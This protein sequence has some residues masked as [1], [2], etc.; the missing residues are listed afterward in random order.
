M[1][2]DFPRRVLRRSNPSHNGTSGDYRAARN[3]GA[4]G[5]LHRVTRDNLRLEKTHLADEPGNMAGFRKVLDGS[6]LTWDRL[7][8]RGGYLFARRG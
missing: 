1:P 3:H 7:T 5:Q 6:G 2:G 8:E 4:T